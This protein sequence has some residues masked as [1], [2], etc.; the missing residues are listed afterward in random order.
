MLKLPALTN[1]A[2]RLRYDH[3]GSCPTTS[4]GYISMMPLALFV[5]VLLV[6]LMV[7]NWCAYPSDEVPI[8]IVPLLV[9]FWLVVRVPQLSLLPGPLVSNRIDWPASKFQVELRL[10]VVSAPAVIKS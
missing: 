10:I 6:E 3:C 4:L 8:S 5:N 2:C 7:S 1:S 9:M